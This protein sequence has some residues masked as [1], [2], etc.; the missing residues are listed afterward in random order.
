MIPGGRVGPDGMGA[1][2]NFYTGIY[3]VKFFKIFS[4]NNLPEKFK[5][6][7]KHPQI[8]QIMISGRKVGPQCYNFYTGIFILYWILYV[9]NCAKNKK[10]KN[11]QNCTDIF[12][13]DL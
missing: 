8:V 13:F 3:K 11:L 6:M 7:W 1:V 12:I 4:K 10:I 5:P 9:K 2:S